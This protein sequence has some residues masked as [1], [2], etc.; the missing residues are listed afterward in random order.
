MYDS[1]PNR[2]PQSL[3]A[4]AATA[5][6]AG[7]R[8]APLSGPSPLN[9]TAQTVADHLSRRAV[10][11]AIVSG[12]AR[13]VD[14]SGLILT[15]AVIYATYVG[16][17]DGFDLTYIPTIMVGAFLGV[18]FIEIAQGYRLG[19]LRRGV[20][21]LPGSFAAWTA[22]LALFAIAA[23]LAKIGDD[24]SRVW[25][26][27]WYVAG[28]AALTASRVGFASLIR[29]WAQ[30]GALERRAVIVGGGEAAE[31]L[32]R[33][34]R[35]DPDANVRICGI[36]DDRKDDRSPAVVAGYPKLGTVAEL[37][38]FGRIAHID[39][40]IVSLPI[41]AENRLLQML[42]KLWVLPV[43][44][45]LSAHTNKLRFRP[46]AYSFIG[47]VPFF[48]I[49]DKPIADWDYFA[50]RVFDIVVSALALVALSPIMIAAAIAIRLDSPGPVLFKQKRYGFNNELIEVYKF[51][52][53]YVDKTDA[54]ASKLVSKGDPRVT[55]V[56]R[57]LR[58]TSIDELPQLFNVL[59]K[60]DLSLVGPR[61]H[62]MQAKAANRLYDEVVDGYFAGHRVKPGIT[63]WAQ[64]NG[65]RGETDTAEKI[66]QRVEHDLHYI[67]NWSL[68][69]DLKILLLTPFRLL[70]TENAY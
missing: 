43:D 14:F 30:S 42:R 50:K 16:P 22:V 27:A 46:R 21:A 13:I 69:L 51:R 38:D 56:G 47:S 18:L 49:Y 4:R 29:A 6:P 12:L 17:R 63:G 40:L 62:A 33:A 60:G 10:S 53:M 55:R 68:L 1:H 70:S 31:Q 2:E 8:S 19:T 32:I 41:T 44:I 15:G 20:A 54:S 64:I 45:R 7:A 28:L 59:L 52:S 48:D 67:E 35:A 65:W 37:V 66:Q 26:G 61:P 24:Y 3:A 57:F 5:D 34:I 23:F 11:P 36:F 25:A 58:K 9:A 39:L